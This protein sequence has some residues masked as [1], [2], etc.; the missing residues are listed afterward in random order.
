MCNSWI[1]VRASLLTA[2]FRAQSNRLYET[3]P[4]I[5]CK[6]CSLMLTL[7]FWHAWEWGLPAAGCCAAHCWVGT[8]GQ[9]EGPADLAWQVE[10]VVVQP[11][12]TSHHCLVPAD[13]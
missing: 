1:E 2:V 11:Q 9:A 8:W 4:Q 6:T 12:K 5:G 13:P 10:G 3:V 7:M